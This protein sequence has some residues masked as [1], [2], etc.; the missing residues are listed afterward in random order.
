M[1]Q[2][3]PIGTAAGPRCLTVDQVVHH[4]LIDALQSQVVV[5]CI[6]IPSMRGDL[7]LILVGSSISGHIIARRVSCVAFSLVNL[8]F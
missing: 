8:L 1:V 2:Q 5:A 6:G 3:G 7:P 4:V